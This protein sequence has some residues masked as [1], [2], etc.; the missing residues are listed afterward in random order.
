MSDCPLTSDELILRADGLNDTGWVALSYDLRQLAKWIQEREQQQ[1]T[2]TEITI[3]KLPYQKH[4]FIHGVRD[5]KDVWLESNG[6]WSEEED[7]EIAE[8][9]LRK[10]LEI[11]EC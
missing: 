11:I 9:P 3:C 5:G 6:K 8:I 10:G 7:S 1:L 4:P 2:I